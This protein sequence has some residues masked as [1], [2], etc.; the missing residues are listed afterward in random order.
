MKKIYL[1]A[2]N[3]LLGNILLISAATPPKSSHQSQTMVRS[4]DP[5]S[6]K[7]VNRHSIL[8][9]SNGSKGIV[10]PSA[11]IPQPASS[12]NS[13]GC[14]FTD[15][16]DGAN[17]T[18]SLTARGYK[19]YYRGGGPMGISPTWFQGNP[20]L[21]AAFDGPTNGYVAANYNSVTLAN[22]IDNWLV[23]PSL[24]L[25]AGDVIS[26]Y[27]RSPIGSTWP[28]SL[29]VWYSPAG[30]SLP[31]DT[32]WIA[33]GHLMVNTLGSWEYNVFTIPSS[34]VNG[35]LAIR[36]AMIDAGPDGANSNYAGIDHLVV[37][38]PSVTDG[39]LSSVTSPA[40]HCGLSASETVTIVINNV[41]ANP[42]NGLSA[43]YTLDSGTAVVENIT[44]TIAPGGT[45]TY[46][47]TAHADLSAT[48]PHT[49]DASVTAAND[50]NSCNDANSITVENYAAANPLTTAYTMSFE[51][52]EDYSGWH[53]EDADGDGVTW[54][55]IDVNAQ[56]GSICMRKAGSG[57]DDDD[58]LFSGCLD[59]T[60]GNNYTLD[61]WYKT[62]DLA[63]QCDLET[64]LA[65]GQASVLVNQLIIQD[66]T[67][68]DTTYQH[69][70][71]TFTVQNSGVYYVAFH[72]HSALG[73]GT[74][75]IR[76]DAIN[77]DD[78]TFIGIDE[79]KAFH[80]VS[81][82]PNPNSG[83]FYLNSHASLKNVKVDVFNITGQNVYSTKNND[84]NQQ[85]IDLSSQAN[86]VYTIR[87]SSDSFVENHTI[88][89]NR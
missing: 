10:Q 75:S 35:R 76:L 54:E 20:T 15:N 30:D 46:N 4:Y 28:D 5:S 63:A 87:I 51:T 48:G 39:N 36:Y 78:G 77:L 8:S 70:I 81:V 82:Y 1:L 60:S 27:S 40:S 71:S 17:D 47:F 50:S 3:M 33:L 29:H 64:Y 67:P 59:L 32:T 49:I 34:A 16:F 86:G 6:E 13:V 21:F 79:N 61:Y 80:N 85:R 19:T 83:V 72:A 52:S 56:S 62:F 43:S 58:W 55:T 9:K 74:S 68:L 41:G 25:H 73:T 66:P 57:Q 38:T 2:L 26:F 31:E 11:F 84:L 18:T 7:V 45:Y 12:V 14:I 22:N 37:F 44:D 65:D 69:S 88:E 53:V 42:I 23:L 24:N 89:I